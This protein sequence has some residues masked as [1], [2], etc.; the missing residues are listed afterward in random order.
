MKI[1]LGINNCFAV[2]RW[3]EP[4]AWARR[5][6]ETLGL[7]LVQFSLDLLDPGTEESARREMI[8]QTLE[9]AREFD[10]QLSSAFTGLAAYSSNLLLH[11]NPLMRMDALAW[12]ERAITLSTELGATAVGGHLGAVS[13]KDYAGSNRREYLESFLI[14]AL[15]HLSNV[16]KRKGISLLLWEPMPLFREAPA[17]IREAERLHERANRNAAVPIEF[18]LDLGHQCTAGARGE[19]RDP[20]E[21]LRQLGSFCPYIH[22]QQTDGEVDHHW[23]FTDQYNT[24]GIIHPEKVIESLDRSGAKEVR[25]IFEIIHP[26]EELEQKVLDDL[27]SSVDFWNRFIS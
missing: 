21:W 16:A 19:D 22:L 8:E 3:P 11:P 20:Y 18:C 6:R 23:P 26:F 14:E 24:T 15:D 4:V 5:V 13:C 1:Q 17:T 7:R 27:K 25:L 2:K 10:L 9:A 12:Y